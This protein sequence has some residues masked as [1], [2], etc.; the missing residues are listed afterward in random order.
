[1]QSPSAYYH[2]ITQY[3]VAAVDCSRVYFFMLILLLISSSVAAAVAIVVVAHHSFDTIVC[4]IDAMKT[5]Q[6][7]HFQSTACA[8]TPTASLLF[9]DI[10]FSIVTWCQIVI[11]YNGEQCVVIVIASGDSFCIFWISISFIYLQTFHYRFSLSHN[12]N[13]MVNR[14]WVFGVSCKV[15]VRIL[16]RLLSN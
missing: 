12:L 11:Y 2:S 10:F 5:I 3:F 16:L 7:C 6:K 9:V 13:G 14:Q 15:R 8:H 4:L 1:M